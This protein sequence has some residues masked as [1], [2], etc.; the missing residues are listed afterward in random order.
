MWC[1]YD[2]RII[3]LPGISWGRGEEISLSTSE[4]SVEL[5]IKISLLVGQVIYFCSAA[6]R[7][8]MKVRL[9][10]LRIRRA[11][12]LW[13]FASEQPGTRL[14]CAAFI[15]GRR[16][17]DAP[18]RS[19]EDDSNE[20]SFPLHF[21]LFPRT[22][23]YARPFHAELDQPST[24]INAKRRDILRSWAMSR[25]WWYHIYHRQCYVQKERPAWERERKRERE[26]S[27]EGSSARREATIT[28]A[29]GAAGWRARWSVS[30]TDTRVF[31]FFVYTYV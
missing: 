30:L 11:C 13:Y 18:S 9:Y 28:T 16:F 24:L 17:I 19:P 31:Q 10:V 4:L 7:R 2:F 14:R 23:W 22:G 25:V 6:R 27:W 26:K 15:H 8:L 29:T 20:E 5:V 21:P 3:I 12:H 1:L